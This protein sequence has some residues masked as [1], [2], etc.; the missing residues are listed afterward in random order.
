MNTNNQ[1]ALRLISEAEQK[2]KSSKGFLRSLFYTYTKDDMIQCYIQAANIFKKVNNWRQAAS[3]FYKAAELYDE[4]INRCDAAINFINASDCYKK[5]DLDCAILCLLK[6][7]DI[8]TTI[9]HCNMLAKNYVT[10]AEI[11]EYEYEPKDLNKVIQYYEY[12][13]KYFD[14]DGSINDV[15]KY[16]FKVANYLSILEHYDKAIINYESIAH[17]YFNNELFVFTIKE[18]LFKACICHLN[19]NL[20]STQ[21]TLDKYHKQYIYLRNDREFKLI[22]ALI[23]YLKEQDIG[24]Y[25]NSINEYNSISYLDNWYMTMFSRIKKKY[26]Y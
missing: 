5:F 25:T 19:I 15:N 9:D 23:K 10:L 22:K 14:R 24:K 8:Y 26:F 7:I 21:T 1:K 12:A 18:Y 2:Y 13:I 3:T 16:M 4:S 6:A 17:S 20:S 11:F